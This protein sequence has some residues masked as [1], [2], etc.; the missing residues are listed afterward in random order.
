[1]AKTGND[2]GGNAAMALGK[3]SVKIFTG[4]GEMTVKQAYDAFKANK[5]SGF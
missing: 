3:A 2:P 1:M 5:L 4:A